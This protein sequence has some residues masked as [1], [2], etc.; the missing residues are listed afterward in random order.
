MA[1]ITIGMYQP[2]SGSIRFRGQDLFTDEGKRPRNLQKAI[3][4][5]YQDPALR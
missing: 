3:Q 4:I 5:V 1:Y 2:T